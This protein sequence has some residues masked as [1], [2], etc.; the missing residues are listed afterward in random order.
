MPERELFVVCNNCGSEVSPYVTECP[1]CGKRLRKRAPDL[2]KQRKLEEKSE[3]KADK[4]REKLRA[5]YE[6][7]G[8]FQRSGG[9]PGAWLDSG[10]TRPIATIVLITAAIVVSLIAR[11]DSSFALHTVFLGNISGHPERLVTAPFVQVGFGVGFVCLTA[12]GLFG[13]GIERRFGPIA[14][15]IVWLVCGAFGVIGEALI[16]SFPVSNGAIAIAVGMFTAWMIVVVSDEDLRDYDAIGLGAV[17]A[18]LMAMPLATDEASVWTLFGGLVGGLICGAVL[19]KLP[20]R[21]TF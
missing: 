11:V 3:R 9:S 1:Y 15:I 5:Q 4:K 17:A 21:A 19:T 20:A 10:A 13:A 8:R 6:G 18:V 2:K 16:A 12:V 14:V 7:G